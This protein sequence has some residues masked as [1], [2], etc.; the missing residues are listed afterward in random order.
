MSE[1][2]EVPEELQFSEM[3]QTFC[4]EDI[5]QEIP[6]S[7]FQVVCNGIPQETLPGET[8]SGTVFFR[9]TISAP[10]G[11]IQLRFPCKGN[12]VMEATVNGVSIG[13]RIASPYY[14]Q[15]NHIPAGTNLELQFRFT[16]TPAPEFR[17]NIFDKDSPFPTDFWNWK[18][19]VH[20]GKFIGGN[21][22]LS[23]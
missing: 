6:S 18:L 19:E 5:V 1:S 23:F 11:P 12:A 17:E 8:F 15:L 9:K 4:S 2:G 10:G 21:G 3:E 22:E 14:F 13:T 16:T 20:K 7:G